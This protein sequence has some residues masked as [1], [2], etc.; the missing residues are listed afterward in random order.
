MTIGTISHTSSIPCFSVRHQLSDEPGLARKLREKWIEMIK[1]PNR[2]L[3]K[4]MRVCE[5]IVAYV[6]VYHSA[7]PAVIVL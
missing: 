2:L 6:E 3:K 1:Q 7:I 4:M 5:F